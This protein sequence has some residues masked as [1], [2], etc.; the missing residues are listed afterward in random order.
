[1]YNE[2]L[3]HIRAPPIMV[4]QAE[5]SLQSSD[6]HTHTHSPTQRGARKLFSVFA[7]RPCWLLIASAILNCHCMCCI[8]YIDSTRLAARRSKRNEERSRAHRRQILK[9]NKWHWWCRW[10]W[11]M[12]RKYTQSTENNDDNYT[13]K[14]DQADRQ[15]REDELNQ[16]THTHADISGLIV[17]FR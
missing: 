9:W 8:V 4:I 5:P 10:L 6:T 3:I 15:R 11:R 1:M 16:I 12:K 7:V 14:M 2:T 17:P 13:A